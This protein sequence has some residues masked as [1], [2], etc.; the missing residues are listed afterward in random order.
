VRVMCLQLPEQEGRKTFRGYCK[1]H[2]MWDG[3]YLF[4]SHDARFSGVKGG[5]LKE[6]GTVLKKILLSLGGIGINPL[7]GMA[8]VSRFCSWEVKSLAL[9]NLGRQKH[10]HAPGILSVSPTDINKKNGIILGDFWADLKTWGPS[11]LSFGQDGGGRYPPVLG[12][13]PF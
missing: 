1:E 8:M 9:S 11:E 5:N 2:L 3:L 6:K 7:R 13:T 10:S 4:L 12:T